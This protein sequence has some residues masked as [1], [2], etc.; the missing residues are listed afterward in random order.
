MQKIICSFPFPGEELLPI[1]Q[2]RAAT[3]YGYPVFTD[4][5]SPLSYYLINIASPKL[6]K[7]YLSFTA[8]S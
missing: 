8:S 5:I 1:L 2:N 7:R 3:D 6:K 4:Q